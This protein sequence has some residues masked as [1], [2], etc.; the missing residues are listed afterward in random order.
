MKQQN[1]WFKALNVRPDEGWLVKKLFL[2]QFFQGA[3]IAFFFTAGFA[4][5][6]A[7]F[8]ITELPYV[9]IIASVML[10]IAGFIYS[11]IEHLF[12]ISKLAII[13]TVFM[14]VSMLFFRVAFAF[15][16]SDWFFY[17]MLAWFN[18]LYLLN[19]LEFWG[20]AS[21]SFDV[22][23]SKRLFGVISAG[24]IPAKFIGYSL[25]LL[26]VSFI[27]TINLIW[28]GIICMLLSVPYLISIKKSGKL[29][30]VQHKKHTQHPP[31]H[32]SEGIRKII[33]NFSEN[34][35]IRR[36]SVLSIIITASFI[37]INYEFYAGVKEAYHDDVSLARFIALFLAAVRIIAMIVKVIFTGRLINN[38]GIIKSLLITPVVLLIL[39]LAVILTKN[40]PES[41]KATIY[42]F[43]ATYIVVDILRSAINSP[44]FLT[45]M[46]PLS[47]H[48]R[49]RA[50]TILKGI[51][52]PFAS[53]ISGVL[54]LLLIKYQ[55][56]VKLMTLS[57]ILVGICI[58]WIVCIYRVNSE[59]LKTIIK[60]ISSRYFIGENFSVSDSGTLEWLKEKAKNGSEIEVINILNM[61]YD[62]SNEM[63]YDLLITALQHPSEKVKLATLKLIQQKEIPELA[64]FLLPFLQNNDSPLLVAET[65][66]IL[67]RNKADNE[68]ILC[69]LEHDN[70]E[71][72]S[73]VIAGLFFYGTDASKKKIAAILRTMIASEN[74][75]ER[76]LVAGI[77]GLQGNQDHISMILQLMNDKDA[78]V[79]KAAFIAAGK[80][81][82]ELLLQELMNRFNTE[83]LSILEPLYLAGES[84]LPYINSYLKNNNVPAVQKEK[85]ILLCGRK[86]GEQAH[87][88]LLELL[89]SH[90]EDYMTIIKA[91]YRSNY[92]PK[93]LEQ[94]AFIS[95]ANKLLTRSAGIIYMQNSL[96]KKNEKYQ[97]LLNSFNLELSSLR[98]CLLYVYA[99]LYDRDNINKVKTAYATGKKA[100]IIN[101]MEIIDITVRKDLA[102]SFNT[103]FEPGNISER[104]HDLRKIYP[105][106][107]FENVERIL[108]RIL[109]EETRPYNNWTM[110]CS[111]YTSKKQQHEID[112]SLIKKYTLAEN[113]L[114]RETALFAL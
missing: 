1:F 35:L 67:C 92:F 41:L 5:F 27:G 22:R 91:M 86:G 18:V 49:L 16:Q 9:F 24:D 78:I 104:M 39:I 107:F 47:N 34:I 71:I 65:I 89:T 100:S 10:W 69:Y 77:L 98:E 80:S 13:I 45:I 70:Q 97:L 17:C 3:G 23:Q 11:K 94:P 76:L 112:G 43:G 48:E 96:L 57:Y 111:L 62:S 50:H 4:L 73:A 6:L 54:L 83:N 88:L 87:Q 75:N 64:T 93:N 72:R 28:I 37:L 55:H 105:V 40:L 74:V 108:T 59:Y 20:V 68:M 8:Q 7:K 2:L 51:M 85:L 38:L 114:L 12:E 42:L 95:I 60:T 61:L 31:K 101:A 113:I 106:E 99:I 109:A 46:Q 82:N 110:A 21:L 25:A 26:I 90:Q 56:E 102:I 63:S 44:V 79:R 29:I 15:V 30:E 58:Y 19:N 14:I 32:S 103:I 81:E 33:K 53:L 52:D 36:L 66:K 84:S